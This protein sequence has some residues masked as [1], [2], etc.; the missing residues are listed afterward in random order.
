[1]EART[2]SGM[3][4]NLTNVDTKA[5][6]YLQQ[7]LVPMGSETHAGEEVPIYASGPKACLVRGTMEQNWIYHVMKEAFGF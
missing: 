3:R 6:G 2:V 1:M 5:L 7:A 4:S